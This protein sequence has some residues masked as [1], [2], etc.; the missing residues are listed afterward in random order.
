MK[1]LKGGG[2][3]RFMLSHTLTYAKSHKK[4][5]RRQ[6]LSGGSIGSFMDSSVSS[7]SFT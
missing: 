3:V 6:G 7:F 5:K 4:N 1:I 2:K